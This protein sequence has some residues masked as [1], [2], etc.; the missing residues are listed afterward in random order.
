MICPEC[1]G[2]KRIY[3]LN[4]LNKGE[5]TESGHYE[6]CPVCRGEDTMPDPTCEYCGTVLVK[7][8]DGLGF[9]C[10]RGCRG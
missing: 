2:K 3:V 7:Q 1:N 9:F 10:P 5:S 8:D 4:T 6:V